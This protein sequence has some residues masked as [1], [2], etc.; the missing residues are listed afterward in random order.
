[1]RAYSL[2][3]G[4][5]YI[6]II[7][8]DSVTA[9][10]ASSVLAIARRLSIYACLSQVG[11]LSKRLDGSSWLLAQMFPSTIQRLRK[12]SYLQNGGIGYFHLELCF[13]LRTYKISPRSVDRRNDVAATCR[14]LS[15]TKVDAI[16]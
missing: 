3:H 13:K 1:M 2:D 5:N 16:N 10:R 15:S 12:F 6:W 8:T 9:T 7:S 4:L 14:Q 11:V